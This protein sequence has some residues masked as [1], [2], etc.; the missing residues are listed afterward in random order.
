MGHLSKDNLH[1]YVIVLAMARVAG[2]LMGTPAAA[3]GHDLKEALH[4]IPAV[5]PQA[6]RA[7]HDA[8]RAEMMPVAGN[9]Q[10]EG[11]ARARKG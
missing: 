9:A 10:A 8:L 5:M 11:S 7:Y 6:G 4:D 2:E 3:S 1:P